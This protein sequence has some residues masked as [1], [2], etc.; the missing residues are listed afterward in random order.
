MGSIE[1]DPK[2]ANTHCTTQSVKCLTLE[3]MSDRSSRKVDMK[4]P[5]YAT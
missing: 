4:L 3:D 5:S 2:S 1:F